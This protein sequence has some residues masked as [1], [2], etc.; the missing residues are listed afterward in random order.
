MTTL[1]VVI[2]VFVLYFV[3]KSIFSSALV[4]A[5]KKYSPQSK[6]AYLE[7]PGKTKH[8]P[9][10]HLLGRASRSLL[11]KLLQYESE[12]P[13]FLVGHKVDSL[14]FYDQKINSQVAFSN[15]LWAK[16]QEHLLISLMNKIGWNIPEHEQSILAIRDVA[17]QELLD[18]KIKEQGCAVLNGPIK[19]VE[20]QDENA[21]LLLEDGT[22]IK[23]RTV[24]A[25]KL[26]KALSNYGEVD[27]KSIFYHQRILSSFC[28]LTEDLQEVY[29]RTYPKGF[30]SLI[31]LEDN[32]AYLRYCYHEEDCSVEKADKN[33]YINHINTKLQQIAEKD[34]QAFFSTPLSY[35]PLLVEEISERTKATVSWTQA[36][37]FQHKNLVLLGDA[38]HEFYPF[39]M[40]D[41]NLAFNEISILSKCLSKSEIVGN[42]NVQAMTQAA[43]YGNFQHFLKSVTQTDKAWAKTLHAVGSGLLNYFP[44]AAYMINEAAHSPCKCSTDFMSKMGR[45]MNIMKQL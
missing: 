39:L 10:V 26:N 20:S 9:P 41:S 7:S 38:A 37:T 8:D 34:T 5:V 29:V 12:D 16:A 42:Y 11:S 32:Q 17:L 44:L 30:V 14:N 40:H 19:N 35:P 33:S 43:A 21:A 4:L 13:L 23:A 22:Q 2:F 45:P 28:K 25:T 27:T 6:I 18:A 24:L 3:G 1:F 15:N 36:A 31:P